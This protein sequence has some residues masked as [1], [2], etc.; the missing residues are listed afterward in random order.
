MKLHTYTNSE[1]V[2]T[3][4]I[5]NT[6]DLDQFGNVNL[7]AHP[8]PNNGVQKLKIVNFKTLKDNAHNG[9][10]CSSPFYTGKSGYKL[11]L[12]LHLNGSKE[13]RNSHMSLYIAIREGQFDNTLIWPVRIKAKFTLLNTAQGD[14]YTTNFTSKHLHRVV[15][16]TRDGNMTDGLYQFIGHNLIQQY[17]KDDMIFI[18]CQVLEVVQ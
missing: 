6:I 3:S 2:D 16:H 11:N 15:H 13:G 8:I 10:I 9:S 4:Q 5:S 17:V 12:G 18:K 1:L 7:V 14:D